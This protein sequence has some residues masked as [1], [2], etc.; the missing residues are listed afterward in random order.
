VTARRFLLC[1][2]PAQ[3]HLAPLLPIAR[4][5]VDDGHEVVLFT[6]EHYRD[7]VTATGARFVPFGAD[8]D[9]HDLMVANPEREVASKRRIG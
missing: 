2:T 6:T 3:G 9:A 5:L 4:R 8:Y 1:S 7:R